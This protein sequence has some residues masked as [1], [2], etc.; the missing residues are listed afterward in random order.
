MFL[1]LK[2]RH[3]CISAFFVKPEHNMKVIVSNIILIGIQHFR[4]PW[5]EQENEI[6][7]CKGPYVFSN[8]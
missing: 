5:R 3:T 6:I 1:L 7:G 2:T 4:F 8:N